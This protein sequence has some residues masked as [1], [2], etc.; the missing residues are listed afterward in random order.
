MGIFS[1]ELSTLY[2]S[3][4][5]GKPS[6]LPAL[7]LQYGDYAAWER[8]S[9]AGDGLARP[10]E[11]WRSRLEGLQPLDV[12]TD[13]PRPP[14][15]SHR[16]AFHTVQLDA[17]L[18]QALRSFCRTHSVTSFMTLLA[19]FKVMLA[20]YTGRN[21]IAVGTYTANRDREELEPLIGFFL[22]TLV[23]RTRFDLAQG[24]G[25][26]LREVRE[27]A[28]GAYAHQALPFATLVQALAPERDLSRNP[29]VQVVFQLQNAASFDSSRGAQALVD[30]QRGAAIFDI[31][32]TCYES[33]GVFH[34]TWEY[35]TDLFEAA[36][37]EQMARHFARVLTAAM[38]DPAQPLHSLPLM[39]D[40]ER[41]RILVDW[42]GRSVTYPD[43]S[44]VDLLLER[45]AQVP[46]AIVFRDGV[47]ALTLG[48]LASR[49][50]ALARRLRAAGVRTGAACGVCLGRGV[51]LPVALF[52]VWRAG[53]VYVPLDPDYPADRLSYMLQDCG[54]KVL[55]G[56]GADDATATLAA[57]TQV[58]LIDACGSDA[59]PDEA[60]LRLV[61]CNL[62][63]VSHVIY[64]SGSTGRPKAAPSPFRQVMNRL[65]WM[66]R[67]EP[68]RAG[69][70]GCVKTATS[71][72]DSLWELLGASLQG[73]PSVV[74]PQATL[75]DPQRT[76]ELLAEH[77]VTRLWLVPTYLRA[78]LDTAPDLGARLPDLR[79]WV[80]SG[81]VLPI[82]LYRRFVQAH[83]DATL[84]NLYGTSEV[85]DATW[86]DPRESSQ[87]ESAARVPI[88]RP[89]DNVTCVLLDR[90]GGLVP[91]R[92]VGE[93]HVGGA[94]M[95]ALAGSRRRITVAWNGR[96]AEAVWACGDLVRW[97]HDGSLEFVG[98]SDGELKIRGMRVE[99]AEVESVLMEHE[100]VR[101][102]ALLA[103][104][105]PDGGLRLVGYVEPQGPRPS[106]DELRA[107]LGERLP[108]FMRIHQF[109]FI[110]ALA[111][112]SS[113]KIDREA[114]RCR[115]D[116]IHELIQVSTR[117]PESDGERAIVAIW[118]ELLGREPGVEENFFAAGGHSLLAAQ[119]VARIEQ[120][121]GVRIELRNLFERPT[122]AALTRLVEQT[123][124]GDA[125]RPQAIPRAE[126]R[127]VPPQ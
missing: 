22:N 30:Y 62:D 28:L 52:A 48:A 45:A 103:W 98:R 96:P 73:V 94:A 65:H 124:R 64:T 38:A 10:L 51:E 87:D 112:T 9:F 49:S 44:P 72:I 53:G 29:L 27:T 43:A 119:V 89:I 117:A 113:G 104:P 99:P 121:L 83:P 85:W 46:D 74:V 70:V 15:Q 57:R 18:S 63:D 14:V 11:Y 47:R 93:L 19:A 40:G 56:D 23:L 3:F 42:N 118:A 111:H 122:I 91:P 31:A 126:R 77:R 88:G 39:D 86:H 34:T 16:G 80:T 69:E 17:A 5:S 55:L 102:A 127:A 61:P 106:P 54:A 114:L 36:T 33:G 105:A 78:L 82:E 20:R 13:R 100:R 107:F 1:R 97:R 110:D 79:F 66:W 4:A 92:V 41:M 71:F 60:D 7:A 68:F 24:F 75:I 32:V 58:R 116:P 26:L 8:R 109:V 37:I 12:P 84:F 76:V 120:R 35:S 125:S 6:S 21:D 95:S 108:S 67:V 101:A 25:E 123:Q 50:E 59:A 90:W 81:E 2:E 115:G